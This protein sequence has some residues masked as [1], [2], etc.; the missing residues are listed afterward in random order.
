MAN[1][2]LL[3]IT[4]SLTPAGILPVGGTRREEADDKWTSQAKEH[5]WWLWTRLWQHKDF[6]PRGVG[7]GLTGLRC[8][9]PETTPCTLLRV[10][11][12]QVP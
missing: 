2:K 3:E 4:L 7:S 12:S 5:S 9:Q 1:S 8:R 11:Q 6:L 10:A